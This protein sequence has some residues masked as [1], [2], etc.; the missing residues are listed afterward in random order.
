MKLWSLVGISPPSLGDFW[1]YCW[2]LLSNCS[3]LAVWNNLNQHPYVVTCLIG[4]GAASKSL[5]LLWHTLH[6]SLM[7]F[8][9]CSEFWTMRHVNV[10]QT[11]V[12][13]IELL[14]NQ[15]GTASGIRTH[16]VSNVADFESA[17]SRQFRHCGIFKG[18]GFYS[19][20][21]INPKIGCGIFPQQKRLEHR[22]QCKSNPQLLCSYGSLDCH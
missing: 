9:L 6:H 1:T 10:Y 21:S 3:I 4:E 22:A 18:R 20:R 16:N 12:L 11:S 17:A 14:I 7:R 15:N 13:I 2:R 5:Q 19:L 8:S